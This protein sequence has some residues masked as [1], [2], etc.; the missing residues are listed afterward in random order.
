MQE[1]NDD[2]NEKDTTSEW[3][4][5]EEKSTLTSLSQRLADLEKDEL[6]NS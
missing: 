1:S 6:R 5:Q 3:V 4:Y 2:N